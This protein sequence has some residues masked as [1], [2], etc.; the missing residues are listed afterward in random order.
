M[1]TSTDR[2]LTSWCCLTW[3]G[4]LAATLLRD[5]EAA[6]LAPHLASLLYLFTGTHLPH[7]QQVY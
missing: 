5:C 4:T 1:S 2:E 6:Q 3:R 7:A